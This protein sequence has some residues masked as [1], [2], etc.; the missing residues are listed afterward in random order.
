MQQFDVEAIL[1]TITRVQAVEFI[2]LLKEELAARPHFAMP[3]VLWD[4]Q[5]EAVVVFVRDHGP[6]AEIVSRTVQEE[7][8]EVSLAVL[9]DYT[10]FRVELVRAVPWGSAA[11]T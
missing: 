4:P 8:F 7:L 3:R 1:P 5:R 9:E 11:E 6:T 2:P 10:S